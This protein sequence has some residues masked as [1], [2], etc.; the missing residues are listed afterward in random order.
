MGDQAESQR[1][2][3]T[4]QLPVVLYPSELERYQRAAEAEGVRFSDWVRSTLGRQ[5][6]LVLGQARRI[7]GG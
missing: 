1:P 6:E 2:R 7:Q 3:R 5:A 4:A